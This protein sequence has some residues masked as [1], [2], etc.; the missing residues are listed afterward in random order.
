MYENFIGILIQNINETFNRDPLGSDASGN[1]GEEEL[2]TEKPEST[3]NRPNSQH[4]TEGWK[5]LE[6]SMSI[7]RKMIEQMGSQFLD[8]DFTP[9]I[10]ILLRSANHLNRFVREIT[11]FVIAAL[12][13]IIKSPHSG[14]VEKVEA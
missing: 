12:F 9:I 14:S 7:M 13:N 8:F 5:S 1:L 6:T 11:Y 2:K 3:V 10:E 4:D